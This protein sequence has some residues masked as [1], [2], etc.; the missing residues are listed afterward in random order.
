MNYTYEQTGLPD[1]K[2]L[3]HAF[4]ASQL[5]RPFSREEIQVK[6][7][8]PAHYAF[9]HGQGVTELDVALMILE[10]AESE[11][12]T[13]Y[14][15]LENDLEKALKNHALRRARLWDC[16]DEIRTN[17]LSD[18]EKAD[19]ALQLDISLAERETFKASLLAMIDSAETHYDLGDPMLLERSEAYLEAMRS[20]VKA[21]KWSFHHHPPTLLD[22]MIDLRIKAVHH[23]LESAR[24]GLDLSQL[25]RID[26]EG[27]GF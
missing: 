18:E 6:I 3:K 21:T 14:G 24:K 17:R 27:P 16:I 1:S 19:R 7:V 11:T 20:L 25:V 15:F 22:D 10:K 9:E 13:V 12:N 8:R 2:L 26:A 5:A 23:T 4:E